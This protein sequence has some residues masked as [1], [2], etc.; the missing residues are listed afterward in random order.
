[1]K[2]LRW[3]LEKIGNALVVGAHVRAGIDDDTNDI[4]DH[5]TG[6]YK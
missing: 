1:M 3:L 2:W 6:K 4:V 5:K